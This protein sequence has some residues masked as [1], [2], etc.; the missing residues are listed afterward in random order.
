MLRLTCLALL[1]CVSV[2]ANAQTRVFKCKGEQGQMIFS[3]QPCGENAEETTVRPPDTSTGPSAADKATW[4]RIAESNE[5]RELRREISRYEVRI[6]DLEEARD[7]DMQ[8]LRDSGGTGNTP[9][10]QT[11]EEGLQPQLDALAAGYQRRIDAEQKRI[12][13]IESRISTLTKDQ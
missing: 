12:D 5:V 8:R 1:C 3:Q 4:R 2:S 7:M 9:P 11:Y 6:R 10:G 13:E